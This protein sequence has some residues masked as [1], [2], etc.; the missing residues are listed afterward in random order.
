[1]T[2]NATFDGAFLRRALTGTPVGDPHGDRV[3]TDSRVP[4]AGALFVALAGP[5][6]DGHAFVEEVLAAGAAGAVVSA[7]WWGA[8][9]R[10]HATDVFV[11]PD[12][13]LALGD[14]ARAHRAR[15][16]VPLAAITGSNGK[17]TTKELLAAALAPLGPVLKTRGNLNNHVGLPLTL[18]ELTGEHRAAAVEI[19]LNHPGE[20]RVLSGIARPRVAVITNV[21]A[22]HL[23]GLGTVAGV[24]R[25]KSEIVAGL[26]GGGTLVVP[27]GDAPL[28]EAL[29]A[30]RGRRVTFGLDPAAG[31]HPERLAPRSDGGTDVILP[32]GVIVPLKLPG[33]HNVRNLLAALAAARALGVEPAAAAPHVAGVEP[34]AGR[35]APR[36]AGGVLILDDTYNANPAS[37][38]ASLRVLAARP[39]PGR[40]HA[41]LGDML[42]LGPDAARL[43]REAGAGAAFVDGLVTV[44]ALAREIGAGAVE[45]G[46]SPAAWREAPDGDAAGALLAAEL[47]PGDVVLVK[48]SRGIRLET[49]VAR[50]LAARGGAG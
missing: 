14:L 29:A 2:S 26:E 38:A 7:A 11:V 8:G 39:E 10:H 6:F 50:L 22:A 35:L 3:L 18:L 44:G 4:V 41:I 24:A 34:V 30:Y 16:P 27:H 20:L 1:M 21:S 36:R 32:G 9:G 43:H 31:L 48:A 5:R 12:T 45:A 40:R 42:E 46:L 19:G 13:A 28:A 37:L 25:A 23:E 33:E 47:A 17:T 49:A 15:R